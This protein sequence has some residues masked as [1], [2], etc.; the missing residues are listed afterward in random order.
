MIAPSICSRCVLPEMPP[1]IQLNDAGV[2]NICLDHQRVQNQNGLLES[3]F[4]KILEKH[5]GRQKYDCLVM[6]SGGRDSTAA[7]YFMKVRY[8]LNPLAF[9]FDHGFETND[10]IDNVRRAVSKLGIDFMFFKTNHMKK[11][12][13]RLISSKSKA[14]ICHPCS[15][16]YM[17]L[18]Y[19]MAAR[20]QAPLIIAGWT[21]GQSVKQQVMSACGCNVHQPEY[22][23]M[24][25]ETQKFL[26]E[27]LNDLPEYKNFPRSMTELLK[28][29]KKRSGAMVLSPHWFLPYTQ[30]EY[31]KIIS[32][33]LGWR[34][35]E[36]SYP[37]KTTNCSL[38]FISVHN[39]MRD[40]GYTHYHV[41]LSKMIR[42]GTVSREDAMKNL[43]MEFSDEML[44]GILGKLNLTVEAIR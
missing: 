13:N 16:W 31:V 5:R 6:C 1:H 20:V 43:N 41:E 38:N 40:Y 21:K 2:C 9:T 36:K 18:A 14:V 26:D 28:K 44:N 32:E 15:I 34:Y 29:V 33:E 3:D 4:I 23:A 8:K 10:A 37:R 22:K 24:A 27:E 11:M 19:D 7:L 42:E 17:D 39:S 12:F 35:P 25:A 30:D